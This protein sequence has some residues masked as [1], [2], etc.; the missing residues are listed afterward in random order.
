MA[1]GLPVQLTSLVLVAG[2]ALYLGVVV[3]LLTGIGRSRRASGTALPPPPVSVIVAARDEGERIGAC[4]RSLAGQS[5]EGALQ[6]VVVDD[7]SGDDTGRVLA[8]LR[9]EWQAAAELVL[10]RAPDPPRFACPKK[11]ALAAGIDRAAGEIL[12]FTD[13][14]CQPPP[15]WV[16]AMVSRFDAGVGLVAGYAYP[17]PPGSVRQRVLALDNLGVAAL[18]EGSIGMEA[19]L[20]CTGRSLAYRRAVY[21]EVGGFEAIGHLVSGDDVYFL[22]LVTART[23]WRI[24]YCADEAASVPSAPPPSGWRALLDQKVRHASKAS[25]YGG[26]ARWLGAAVYLYHAALF[27]GGLLAAGGIQAAFFLCCWLARWLADLL[28]LARFAP[29]ASDRS[30]LLL[31]PVAEILYIPYVLLLVPLGRAGWFRWK[32]G[33]ALPPDPESKSRS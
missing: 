28:L 4:V 32:S 14:D 26:G 16:G 29:R 15:E 21:D 22:R 18:A 13:A 31:L 24:R 20:A 3:W 10:V 23:G 6:I 17:H 2:T 7:R 12:L 9:S 30:G 8:A 19:P 25:R 1:G 33:T 27:A 11:S 5:Y